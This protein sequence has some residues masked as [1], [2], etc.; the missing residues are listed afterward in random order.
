MSFGI[1]NR[2]LCVCVGVGVCGLSCI[3]KWQKLTC[4]LTWRKKRG[5]HFERRRRKTNLSKLEQKNFFFVVATFTSCPPFLFFPYPCKQ[6]LVI[7]SSVLVKFISISGSLKQDQDMDAAFQSDEMRADETMEIECN[8]IHMC[9]SK[10]MKMCLAVCVRESKDWKSLNMMK[11]SLD[12]TPSTHTP[13]SC[14][15]A[16]RWRR[17]MKS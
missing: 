9:V 4:T 8:R 11:K 15:P 6:E 1:G 10:D 17:E 3:F 5:G 7:F 13:C 16:R 14:C 12:H 2:I